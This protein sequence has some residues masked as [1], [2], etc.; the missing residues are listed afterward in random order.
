MSARRA[1]PS[2]RVWP[3]FS[4]R[5]MKVLGKR[6][7]RFQPAR[8]Q[9]ILQ[10]HQAVDGRQLGLKSVQIGFQPPGVAQ[11]RFPPPPSAIFWTGPTGPSPVWPPAPSPRHC[12]AA[13]PG[14]FALAPTSQASPEGVRAGAFVL[15]RMI[16]KGAIRAID[17]SRPFSMK[18]R[19]CNAARRAGSASSFA[20]SADDS[21]C[22][23]F[24]D[25]GQSFAASESAL[26]SRSAD[27]LLNSVALAAVESPASSFVSAVS[28]SIPAGEQPSVACS[29][30]PEASSACNVGI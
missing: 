5:A 23:R 14:A 2:G 19:R 30:R 27:C 26:R 11:T 24:A 29:Q 10:A 13:P 20:R 16:A 21:G 25:I 15:P 22:F 6:L 7:G 3:R 1:S 9:T 12:S 4:V 8:C 17:E 28:F 18:E